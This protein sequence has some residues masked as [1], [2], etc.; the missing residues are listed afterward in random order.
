MLDE[1]QRIE[2]WKMDQFLKM[3]FDGEAIAL[4]LS[5]DADPHEAAHLLF[6]D[7]KRTSCTHGQALRILAPL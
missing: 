7:G 5:W 1:E 6:R 4:L 2:L 3:A